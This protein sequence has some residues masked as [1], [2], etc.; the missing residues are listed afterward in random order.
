MENV[1]YLNLF[2]KNNIN[3]IQYFLLVMRSHLQ[4]FRHT[5]TK[6]CYYNHNTKLNY[7]RA[8]RYI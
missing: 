4:P 1:C 8:L 3:V 2:F 7:M 5:T 6:L